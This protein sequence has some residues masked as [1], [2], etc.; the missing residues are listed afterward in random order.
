[1]TIDVEVLLT[2][3]G[4]R[5][6][7]RALSNSMCKLRFLLCLSSRGDTKNVKSLRLHNVFWKSNVFSVYVSKPFTVETD[8]VYP[9]GKS[10]GAH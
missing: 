8:L 10:T 7:L 3:V 9:P 5:R 2:W 6:C 1:M 4:P